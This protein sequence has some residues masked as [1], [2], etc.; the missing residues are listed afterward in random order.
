M[1]FYLLRFNQFDKIYWKNKLEKLYLVFSGEKKI[2][3]FTSGQNQ[4]LKKI[5]K[6]DKILLLNCKNKI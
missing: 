4:F 1:S 3:N 2:H 5:K 6:S